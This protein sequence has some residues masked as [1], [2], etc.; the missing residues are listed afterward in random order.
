MTKQTILV[1][2]DEGVMEMMLDYSN[3]SR[4]QMIKYL[5]SQIRSAMNLVER[6]EMIEMRNMV[7]DDE[8]YFRHQVDNFKKKIANGEYD[9]YKIPERRQ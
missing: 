9:Q 2:T 1:D 6:K 3:D 5:E 8:R 7:R 4:A